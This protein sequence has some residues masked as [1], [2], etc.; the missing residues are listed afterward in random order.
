MQALIIAI[1]VPLPPPGL[2]AVIMGAA[3]RNKC[4]GQS[5]MHV[6]MH[7][8]HTNMHAWTRNLDECV[9]V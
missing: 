6:P 8:A 5:H 9:F 2:E 1:I 3:G 7:D 4:L